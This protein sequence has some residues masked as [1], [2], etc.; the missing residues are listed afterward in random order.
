VLTRFPTAGTPPGSFFRA[1][2]K[3][4]N[5]ARVPPLAPIDDTRLLK[6]VSRLE[7]EVVVVPVEEA[8]VESVLSASDD[9]SAFDEFSVSM[10]DCSPRRPCE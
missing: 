9:P 7:T 4:P 2:R 3:L 6:L 1:S 10:R 5:V 8:T